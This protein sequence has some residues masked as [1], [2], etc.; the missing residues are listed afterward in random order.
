MFDVWWRHKSLVLE[1][2]K[3]EFSGRYRGSFGGLAWSFVHPLFMLSVY[4]MAFGVILKSRWGIAGRT[5]DY[6]LML[7]SGLIIFNLFA[8]CLAKAPTLIIAQPN[9]VKKIVFPLE[10]LPV[11]T[12]ISAVVNALIAVM[13]WTLGYCILNG[14]PHSSMLAFPLVFICMIPLLLGVGWLF[15]ALGVIVRDIS[16][17]TGMLTQTLL[18]LTPIFYGIEAA[19]AMLRRILLLNPLTILVEQFRAVLV[20]GRWPQLGELTIYFI[21][22]SIFAVGSLW[23]FRRLRS[24]FADFV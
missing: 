15:S 9:F 24:S 14:I 6:A 17:L 11:V 16:H 4:T 18:F 12:V 3:R 7:F 1:L 22:S 21:F 10:L 8:E 2:C 13:V 20:Y 19:P 23:V 5:S